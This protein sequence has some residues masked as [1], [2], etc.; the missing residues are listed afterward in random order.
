MKQVAHFERIIMGGV[1]APF[2]QGPFPHVGA[3]AKSRQPYL[4]TAH[5]G[6]GAPKVA[7]RFRTCAAM[8]REGRLCLRARSVRAMPGRRSGESD[9]PATLSWQSCPE[10]WQQ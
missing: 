3:A 7:G 10:I 9:L 2:D 5:Y 6:G 4:F 1:G 8:R